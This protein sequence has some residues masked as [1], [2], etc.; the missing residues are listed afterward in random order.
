MAEPDDRSSVDD[1]PGATWLAYE[2]HDGLLQWIISA[3]MNIESVSIKLDELDSIPDSTSRQLTSA[4]IF[5]D[6][7]LEEGRQLIQFLEG[8]SLQQQ[9]EL[10][11]QLSRFVG[12]IETDV[13]TAGQ[14]IIMETPAGKWPLLQPRVA[15]NVLRIL[16]QALIN[17]NRHAGQCEIRVH[18]NQNGR[19]HHFEI[20]DSGTGFDVEA[21]RKKLDRYGLPGMEHRA[22]LIDAELDIQSAVGIGTRIS[23]VVVSSASI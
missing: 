2:L 15:W 13:E 12:M 21:S 16:Q 6:S 17:A 23:L 22:K 14:E 10:G 4:Q 3:K 11:M 9:S 7:A 5:L 8:Q 19:G 18:Y 1:E 20:A